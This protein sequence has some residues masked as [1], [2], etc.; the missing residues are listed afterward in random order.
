MR[1][2]ERE[3]EGKERGRGEREGGGEGGRGEREGGERGR[4]GREGGRGERGREGNAFPKRHPKAFS[5]SGSMSLECFMKWS[6]VSSQ[7]SNIVF[8]CQC[9]CSIP[10]PLLLG[11]P[12]YLSSLPNAIMNS[13]F[14]LHSGADEKADITLLAKA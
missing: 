5:L 2:G 9:L 11:P 10:N 7:K 12:L 14:P 3:R 13:D 4:E 1:N 8:I 6:A